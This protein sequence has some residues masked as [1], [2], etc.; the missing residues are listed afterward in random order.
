VRRL[1]GGVYDG[2]RMGDEGVARQRVMAR[3]FCMV[4]RASRG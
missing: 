4:E 1:G 2:E 3:Y